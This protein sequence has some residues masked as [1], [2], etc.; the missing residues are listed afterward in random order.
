MPEVEKSKEQSF[1]VENASQRKFRQKK[2]KRRSSTFS[3]VEEIL[4]TGKDILLL[5]EPS[6]ESVA[7]SLQEVPEVKKDITHLSDD[8]LQNVFWYFSLKERCTILSRVCK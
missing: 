2:K 6:E 3:R 1:A 7:E 8:I 5:P 4:S